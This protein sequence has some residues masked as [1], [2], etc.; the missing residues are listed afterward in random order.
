MCRRRRNRPG[1]R[2][3]S[4]VKAGKGA[5]AV[6]NLDYAGAVLRS[7]A[8]PL[9]LQQTLL[10]WDGLLDRLPIGV[11]TVD[12]NGVLV[13]Y[14]KRAAALWGRAPDVAAGE[15]NYSG[16]LRTY[17]PT[18]EALPASEAPVAEVLRTRHPVRDCELIVE[19]RDG[20]RVAILVNADPLF[21]S[22]GQ[23]IGA[24]NCF[25]D[26]TAR[27]EAEERLRES[28]RRSQEILQALPAAIYT[29][30]AE[31]R[32]TFYNKAAA[33]LAGREPELGAVNWCVTW[34]LFTSD[35]TP[36]PHDECPMAV[37]LKED[38]EVRGVEG[39]AEW[40][41]GTRVPFIAFPTPLHDAEG[42][43]IGAVN[44]LVDI[45]ERKSAEERQKALV[46]ELNH[47]VKN[48]LATVQALAAQTIRGDGLALD[49]RERFNARLLALSR[50]HDQLTRDRWQS[51]D[52][53]SVIAAVVAPY[54]DGRV[55]LEGTS[56]RVSPKVALTLAMVLHEL[57]TNAAKYG[58]LSAPS[59][60]LKL[61]WTVANGASPSILHMDWQETGG[62]AV[63]QPQRRGFGSRLVERA[64]A[65]ELKGAAKLEFAPS[66]VRC[67]IEIPLS[68]GK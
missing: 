20:S 55:Q 42:R 18:G 29:T 33:A 35:G 47:R 12:R 10:S 40:P 45:S 6:H 41:D 13:Q 64:I 16:A 2:A 14:N 63:A 65:Q 25:Q 67:R 31:G 50:A 59:G 27:K 34:K 24:V 7:S 8:V 48:T 58:A 32:I 38:R 26:I 54:G 61:S 19:R 3:F 57:A 68:S 66:G 28:E 60:R 51:T 15:S 5:A 43:L 9:A 4:S 11:Y 36:L 22:S 53:K 39:I 49:V 52:V 30:D 44:M 46:D 62:P 21:D 56:L 17:R 1:I 23:L 37:A